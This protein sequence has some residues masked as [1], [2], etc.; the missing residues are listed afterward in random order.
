V[1]DGEAAAEAGETDGVDRSRSR[2][3]ADQTRW[4]TGLGRGSA[5]SHFPDLPNAIRLRSYHSRR[6]LWAQ[7]SARSLR[8]PISMKSETVIH[9]Q[10]SFNA[11]CT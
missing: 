9:H 8:T 6:F 4:L 11:N 1:R 10:L 5:S 7:H 2:L 3:I